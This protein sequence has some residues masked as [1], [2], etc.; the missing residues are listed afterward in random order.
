MN[1]ARPAQPA[2]SLGKNRLSLISRIF[3]APERD[4]LDPLYRAIVERGRDPFWYRDAGVPDT[5]DG[6]FDMIAALVAL[7]L[8]RLEAEGEAGRQPSVLLTELFVDDMDSSLRE[9][10][11]GDY[12]V[13]KHVGRMMGALGGRLTAVRIATTDGALAEAVERNIFRGAPPSAEA[14]AT[15]AARLSGLR[16]ALAKTPLAVLLE[17]RLPSP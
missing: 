1:I 16:G 10:G 11:I 13:G 15:V 4:M 12:V 3:G 6:R 17:G 8:L 2:P 9:I 14:V 5:I 7:V